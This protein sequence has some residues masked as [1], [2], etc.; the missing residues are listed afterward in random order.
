MVRKKLAAAIAAIG[1]LQ[2]GVVSALGMG[3]F[4]LNSALNQPLDAEI[5]LTNIADLDA[6]Q[7]LVK[8]ASPADF[9]NAGVSRDFFLTNI[10]FNVE[11]DGNGSGIIRVTTRQPVVEPY[12]NFLVEA[13]WPSGRMLREFTVLLDLPVFSDS[14]AQAV[15]QA[16]ASKAEASRPAATPAAAAVRQAPAARQAQPRRDGDQSQPQAGDQYRVKNDDTL[17]EIA[18]NSRP[19]ADLSVQQTMLGIQRLNPRA[20]VNGNI[21]R[22]KAGSVLRLPT[23]DQISITDR[24]AIGEVASHN[25]AWKQG[26]S[27]APTADVQLDATD[28]PAATDAGYTDTP[29]LS[30]ASSGGSDNSG[31]SEGE[32]TSNTAGGSAL[33]DALASAEENLDKTSMEN[34][35]LQSRLSDMESKLATLQRLI[36][37]KD[38]QLAALQ[39][40]SATDTES[41]QPMADGSSADA[42]TATAMDGELDAE[43][44]AEQKAKAEPVRAASKPAE[45]GLLDQ[46][47]SNPLYAGGA[48][49]LILAIAA[50]VLMRR[51]K[52]DEA[53]AELDSEFDG[54]DSEAVNDFTALSSEP[55]EQVEDDSEQD[56]ATDLLV[57]ELESEIA[58]DN[59][60]E[61][62]AT[63][64]VAASA[65][66]TT[67]VESE[68]GDVI[69]EADIYVAY[70][71][72]QQAIDLL[73]TGSEQ[74]PERSDL[75]LKLLEVYIE[76][77]DKPAFQ[78]Q[79]KVLQGL[80][81]AAA[82]EQVKEMLS[83]VDGVS[84]WLD[85]LSG[86]TSGFTDAD[87]DA[88]LIEG[89]NSLTAED[90]A[91]QLDD[92]DLSL[93]EELDVADAAVEE[94]ELDLDDA[95]DSDLELDLDEV[96][97]ADLNLDMADDAELEL[98]LDLDD[99]LTLDLS[100]L[101]D[102]TS[103]A[104][105]DGGFDLDEDLLQDL[106]AV[107]ESEEEDGDKT[108]QYHVSEL[109][110][111]L[112]TAADSADLTSTDL[113]DTDSL[114]LDD[115]SFD[116][117]LQLDEDLALDELAADDTLS[118][119]G[120]TS[121]DEFDLDL[122]EEL[123]L[124][125]LA[126]TDLGDLEAE[127]G[128]M[129][130]ETTEAAAAEE[131]DSL[132]SDELADI[133]EDFDLGAIAESMAEQDDSSIV[134]LDL[135][136]DLDSSGETAEDATVEYTLDDVA[137]EL[138]AKEQA[139]PDSSDQPPAFDSLS[140]SDE[141]DDDFDFLSDTD[142]VATKLD[143]ARA[144][145]D[146]GDSEGAR[147]ILEE[148]LAEGSEQ[149]IQEANSLVEKID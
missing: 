83:T 37:L 35:D 73:R 5:R 8:M 145:I 40:E 99:D 142:E 95:G 74:E 79:F 28:S 111:Q 50:I 59:A 1:A 22:L 90:D 52:S 126:D 66:T 25:R 7:V 148:V 43:L 115:L 32:G 49:L 48:G 12:L 93:D 84:D 72:Y 109:Q 113:H 58:A 92:I 45:Q 30:I 123:N 138:A 94:L 124:D 6:S 42:D 3:D 121:S 19:G 26:G 9:S 129:G 65:E 85:G 27:V 46:M 54:P 4:S 29:R 120:T 117:P 100:E 104:A 82:I 20:F 87:M 118:A 60:E 143:L 97:D 39:L 53:E 2:A 147:D 149:Q 112:D 31:F 88:D 10:K 127:F 69:A 41:T 133:G 91:L 105:D 62:A 51:R 33:Q 116:E 11:V 55:I 98:D 23:R 106:D 132:S 114:D 38:D 15:T 34:Q 135:D 107:S 68:T 75:Q 24:Q 13:H 36:E 67:A 76:T 56:E 102:G 70:G 61:Q 128:D 71:R 110:A 140:D 146:M 64:A 77:R 101:D 21:N 136:L 137:A 16:V 141:A 18:Q 134:G 17:W 44:A 81:D 144:Y 130:S 122:D 96:S 108:V 125:S 139:A 119:D 89:E 14:S 86:D 103:T 131:S 57:A 47:T 63:A 78:Q 80:G